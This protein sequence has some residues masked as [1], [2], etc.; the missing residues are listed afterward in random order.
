MTSEHDPHQWYSRPVLF[1]TSC[2]R[3]RAFYIDQLEFTLAWDTK[4]NYVCQVNHG[5]CEIILCAEPDRAGQSRLFIELSKAGHDALDAVVEAK[6][7][8]TKEV[9]WG[10]RTLL[11]TDPDGN[12]LYFPYDEPTK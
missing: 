12:E 11:I 10:Y 5:D 6:S 3:A 2:E 4:D 8:P 9:Q 1:V 7:I